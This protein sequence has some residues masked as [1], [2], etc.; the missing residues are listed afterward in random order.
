MYRRKEE[1]MCRKTQ[2]S[3]IIILELVMLVKGW[4]DWHT[5]FFFFQFYSF[6]YWAVLG[7]SCSMWNLVPWPVIKPGPCRED[8]V[9]AP[10]QGSPHVNCFK[11]SSSSVLGSVCS[12]F[13]K[14]RRVSGGSAYVMTA[15]WSSNIKSTSSTWWGFRYL[16]NSSKNVGQNTICWLFA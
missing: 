4:S 6:I 10:G 5:D 1:I 7:L 11:D 15:I 9:L 16:N 8:R 2:W 3:L 13:L 14:A 12:H